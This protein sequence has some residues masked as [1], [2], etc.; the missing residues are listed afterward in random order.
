MA[1]FPPEAGPGRFPGL[2]YPESDGP[3]PRPGSLAGPVWL[4]GIDGATWDLIGPMAAKGELPNFKALMDAGSWSV[5][6][7]EEPTISPALWATIATGQP[8]FVHGIVNFRVRP[9]GTYE[10]VEA[11]PLDRRSPALWELAGA[12]GGTS[13]VVSWFGSYPAEKIRGVYLSMRFDPEHLRAGQVEPASFAEKLSGAMVRMRKGDYERIGWS[14][15]YR[16]ALVQDARTLAAFLLIASQSPPDFAALYFSGVD[17]VQHLT[18]RHMDPATQAYPED[19]PPDP[20]LAGVIPAYY[21]YVDDALGRI[22]ETAPPGTTLVVVSDHGGGPMGREEALLLHLPAL[23]EETGLMSGTK[24]DLFA[25]SALYRHEKPIWLNLAGIEPEGSVPA[26]DAAARAREAAA[27]LAAL[28]TDAGEPVF[29]SIRNLTED[30]S[31]RPGEP[32]L[33]VRFS[34]AARTARGILDG[35][36]SLDMTKIRIRLPDVTGSHRLEGIFLAAGPAVR[37][38]RLDAPASIYN[39]APTLLYLLGLPQDAR[40]LRRAPEGGGVLEAAIRPDTL[41]AH[42]VAMVPEYPGTGRA[43]LLRAARPPSPGEIDPT[44]EEAMEKLRSLGYIH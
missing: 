37:P 35:D 10:P 40:M 1:G 11:G 30:P 31:W 22:R 43:G 42:P 6:E 16:K 36:M 13:A 44:H 21:R 41:A 4:V 33:S 18:W 25:V 23:L 34:Y 29:C 32:A 5:L 39:V 15:D 17:V 12:A 28:R 38:G 19:G 14:E 20:D 26:G 2:S 9:A 27:R 3:L 24:G 7:S 8:R